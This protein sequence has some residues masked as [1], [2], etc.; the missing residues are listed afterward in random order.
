MKLFFAY[1]F[2]AIMTLNLTLPLVE[3][4]QGKNAYELTKFGSDDAD[5]EGNSEKEKEKEKEKE[6][7][8]YSCDHSFH[9]D[10]H[11]LEKFKKTPFPANDLPVSELFASLPELPPEV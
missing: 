9:L 11:I 2:L 4:L 1:F 5:E 6:S 7:I 3:R 10:A 8:S